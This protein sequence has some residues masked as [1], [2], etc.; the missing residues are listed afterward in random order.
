MDPDLRSL[1]AAALIEAI[2]L[3]PVLGL[4]AV[5]A[6]WRL[7]YDRKR[8]RR[9]M[10]GGRAIICGN[11]DHGIAEGHFPAVA[12]TFVHPGGKLRP[13]D[14]PPGWVLIKCVN[15]L[16]GNTHVWAVCSWACAERVARGLRGLDQGSEPRADAR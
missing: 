6:L 11:R 12:P 10:G 16:T 13:R 15:R 4:L 1:V 2:G 9:L 5:V 14:L 8:R 7:G 3:W